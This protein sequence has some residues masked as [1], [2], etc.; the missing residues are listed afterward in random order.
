MKETKILIVED[1]TI[2]AHDIQ[3]NLTGLGYRVSSIAASGEDAIR[4]ADE[5]RPN[6]VLMDIRIRGD[7][8][9]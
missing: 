7:G 4:E 8:E 9:S 2:I 6:L 3:K 5:K 1:E